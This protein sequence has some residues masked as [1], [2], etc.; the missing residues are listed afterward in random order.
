MHIDMMQ[1]HHNNMK[2]MNTTQAN[3]TQHA[4]PLHGEDDIP[5]GTFH[6]EDDIPP[7]TFHGEDDIPP[8]TFH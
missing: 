7:G 3:A 2:P 8:G 1:D 6:G 4:K 5:P